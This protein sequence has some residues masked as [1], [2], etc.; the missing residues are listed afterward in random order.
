MQKSIEIIIIDTN[1]INGEGLCRILDEKGFGIVGR[2]HAVD[3]VEAEK[4][5]ARPYTV[6][7]VSAATDLSG[8]DICTSLH[9]KMPSLKILVMAHSCRGQLVA[10]AFR[11]GADG[12]VDRDISCAGLVETLKLIALGEKVMPSQ[13][14]FDLI[15][16][17][18]DHG[19]NRGDARIEEAHVSVREIEILR[20][21]IAG[22][23]NKVISRRLGIT[24]ATV[25]VHVKSILRKLNV[26]NRTQAAI[27]AVTRGLESSDTGFPAE[28]PTVAAMPLIY[29]IALKA[30]P[31]S[32]PYGLSRYPGDAV[33][34]AERCSNGKGRS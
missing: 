10:D 18:Y 1:E 28:A 30:P 5:G 29:D 27:W 32:M 24:E 15:A 8:L 4:I 2:Y 12:Y 17:R 34:H 31:P 26:M 22:E 21:L 20:G 13:L 33:Q 9:V 25:K 11:S 6:A 16:Q 7:I 14:V 3:D 19:W 23:P